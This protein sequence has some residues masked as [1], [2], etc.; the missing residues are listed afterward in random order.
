VTP[1]ISF[2]DATSQQSWR[3]RGTIDFDFPRTFVLKAHQSALLV[4]FDPSKEPAR[5]L[6]WRQKW[7]LD[8]AV[9][10]LGPFKG[11]IQNSEGEL[12]LQK[13]GGSDSE[14][15]NVPYIVV[16]LVHYRD[17]S[18]W[19]AGADGAGASLERKQPF[20]FG[21]DADNWIA[22]LPSPG[23]N[24]GSGSAPAIVSSPADQTAWVAPARFSA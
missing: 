15:D 1:Q 7:A 14:N 6:A 24:L 4:S 21:N 23:R 20:L 16:D 9:E 8:P 10:I 17:S 18:P 3:L 5:V 13:P 12:S 2:E 22:A 19:P 11:K